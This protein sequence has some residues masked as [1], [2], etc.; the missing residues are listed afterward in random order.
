MFAIG[1][2]KPFLHNGKLLRASTLFL[3]CVTVTPTHPHLP[4][5]HTFPRPAVLH[6]GLRIIEAVVVSLT[7]PIIEGLALHGGHVEVVALKER[8]ARALLL[9]KPADLGN[10]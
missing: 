5:R 4:C 1:A 9:L 7:S 2:R 10:L 3:H 8:S 6:A